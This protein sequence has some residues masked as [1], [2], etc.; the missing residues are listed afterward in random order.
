M[1]QQKYHLLLKENRIYFMTTNDISASDNKLSSFS[2]VVRKLYDAYIENSRAT[3]L[4]H[5]GSI[6]YED[7]ELVAFSDARLQAYSETIG[8][9]AIIR[10]CYMMELFAQ[11]AIIKCNADDLIYGSQKFCAFRF[12]PEVNEQLYA[13][14]YAHNAGHIVYN[15][16]TLLNN[17]I[18]GLT[19][20]I[21]ARINTATTDDEIM[22]LNAF[23]RGLHAFK[24]FINRHT[25]AALEMANSTTDDNEKNNLLKMALSL[26][27]LGQGNKSETFHESLQLVWFIQIFLHAE[28]PSAAISFGRIDQCLWPFLRNDLKSQIITMN[29]AANLIA[30]FYLRCC[31]GEESQNLTLGGVD[32]DGN[33]ATN[34]LSILMLHVMRDLRVTQPSLSVRIHDTTP[35]DFLL[36]ACKLAKTGTGQPGFINDS[37]AISGLQSA[38]LSLERARDYGIVGCYEATSQGDCYPNTVGGNIPTL[39][40]LL[41]EY[42]A[43]ETAQSADKFPVFLDGWYDYVHTVYQ[44]AVE[45]N[46]QHT[47]NYWRDNAPSSFSSTLMD[48]CI[49]NALPVEAGGANYNLFG[50]NILGLGTTVD[51]LHAINEVAFKNKEITVKEI[52]EEIIN[53]F[54]DELI[55]KKLSTITGK[56]GTDNKFTNQLAKEVSTKIATMVLNSRMENNLRPYPAFFRFTADIYDHQYATPD[57]RRKQDNLSYGCGPANNCGGTPT[58]ILASVSNVAHHLCG[59]GNPLALSLPADILHGENGI[60]MLTSLIKGYFANGGFHLHFN[61]QSAEILR[62]AKKAPETHTDVTI[63]IS[64]L[65]AKFVTLNANLQDALIERADKGV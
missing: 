7:D 50:I 42:L 3:T 56:Y 2:P 37:S 27:R 35:D 21:K 54:P 9:P 29:E 11:N 23:T 10:R 16:A 15:Y 28:N 33:D 48:G 1:I 63:R 57:G 41:N 47:W 24:T 5:G 20:R 31:E 8:Q 53:D 49:E 36:E 40:K 64:G 65:S 59:C 45:K 30:A 55:R 44:K 22:N 43:T 25:L 17:G 26:K 52:F 46:Y 62:L 12:T 39:P 14:G 4:I 61:L 58:S 60:A 32:I 34:P 18:N 13:A 51:S 6:Y 38:G 19:D